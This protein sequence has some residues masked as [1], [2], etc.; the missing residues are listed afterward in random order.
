LR[1]DDPTAAPGHQIAPATLDGF[2]RSVGSTSAA[3]MVGVAVAL[4]IWMCQASPRP[5]RA[6]GAAGYV[7]FST[8]PAGA[9]VQLDGRALGVTPATFALPS[10]VHEFEVSK[11]GYYSSQV[12]VQVPRAAHVPVKLPL[13]RVGSARARSDLP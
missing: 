13:I 3:A 4:T 8:E 6:V 9:E 11:P 5:P 1:E 12:T 10:G 7:D 2:L